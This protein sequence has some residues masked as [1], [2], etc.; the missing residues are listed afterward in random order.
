MQRVLAVSISA[1]LI[2]L[3]LYG[4][5]KGAG[6]KENGH[7]P[8]I[9]IAGST[10]MM[11]ISEKLAR[12]YEARHPGVKIHIE[13]G[14]SSVGIRGVMEGILDIGSVS[15]SLTEEEKKS[16]RSYKITEDSVCII[17]NEKNPVRE[18]TINQ[19][20]EVFSGKITNWS[21]VGGLNRPVT[22]I[23]REKGSGTHNVFEDTV[24]GKGTAVDEKAVVMT[25][26]GAVLGAVMRDVNAIGYVSSNYQAGD[27]RTLEIHTGEDKVFV[28]SR[29]LFYIT[30]A[31]ASELT[32]SYLEF[33]TGPEGKRIVTGHQEN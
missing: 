8:V 11:P 10:S 13:G 21:E 17:V 1:L 18:L 5:G 22:V 12:A 7:T 30:P 32:R 23:S 27:V 19:V 3:A 2:S 29:P 28:L 14:D 33:C 20:R 24:M 16:L 6:S 9:R 26:T 4:C 31:G 15:R 25:S